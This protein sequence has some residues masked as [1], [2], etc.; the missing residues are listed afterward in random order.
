MAPDGPRRLIATE[1]ACAFP[2]QIEAIRRLAA[3]PGD[4]PDLVMWS[5]FLSPAYAP[6]M[7]RLLDLD[8]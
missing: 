5:R 3:H 7:R 6:V 8:E 2:E 4:D 1:E